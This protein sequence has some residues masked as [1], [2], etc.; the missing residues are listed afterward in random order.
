MPSSAGLPYDTHRAHPCVRSSENG[1]QPF[2][3]RKPLRVL[4]HRVSRGTLG[5]PAKPCDG[6]NVRDDVSSVAE[7]VF[8]ADATGEIRVVLAPNDFGELCSRIT[9]AAA[10]I[11]YLANGSL[12]G[13]NEHIGVDHV[14][15]IDVVTDR[16]PVLV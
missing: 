7:P 11:E 14:M 16:F 2:H 1:V 6:V 8:A 4:G 13:E 15:D 9:G 5:R 10:D 12:I 3:S